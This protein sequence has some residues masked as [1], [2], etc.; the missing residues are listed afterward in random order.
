MP[1]A[2]RPNSAGHG[3]RGDEPRRQGRTLHHPCGADVLGPGVRPS[4]NGTQPVE[5]R[6]PLGRNEVPVAGAPDGGLSQSHTEPRGD[7]AGQRPGSPG[8]SPDSAVTGPPSG[9][10]SPGPRSPGPGNHEVRRV[11]PLR[12]PSAPRGAGGQRVA[13]SSSSRMCSRAA[14]RPGHADLAG[15]VDRGVRG[16]VTRD[17]LRGLGGGREAVSSGCSIPRSPAKAQHPNPRA[18]TPRGRRQPR[19]P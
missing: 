8:R 5:H 15:A 2:R 19:S 9:P 17:D 6:D 1:H 4:S 16:G 18:R 7:G 13:P 14:G 3:E 11:S 10:R 12:G